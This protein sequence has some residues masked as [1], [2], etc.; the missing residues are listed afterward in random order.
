MLAGGAGVRLETERLTLREFRE[1]DWSSMLAYWRDPR[2]G[3]YYP[4]YADPESFVREL[5]AM[6]VGSQSVEP[7]RSFQ[8]A[9]VAGDEERLIG[10]CG[11][12][13]NNAD[14]GEANIGYELDPQQWGKGYATEAAQAIVAFG[15]DE[16]LLHRIW[17]ECVADNVGSARVLEKLGM[18]REAQLREHQFYRDRWWDTLIYAVLDREWR[19]ARAA[20]SSGS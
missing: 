5:V 15:F 16:L 11:I 4:E 8:L 1:D 9:I 6:F 17:A 7:R 12:R 2:Y 18:R 10:N 13:V 3:R 20:R 19:A 14:L